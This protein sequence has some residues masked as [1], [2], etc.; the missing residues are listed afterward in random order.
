MA[1]AK[2]NQNAI[3]H[4]I[5]DLRQQI[6]PEVTRSFLDWQA[7]VAAIGKAQSVVDASQ[8][9]LHLAER[10]YE[11][12]LGNV[13]ELEDA[14]TRFTLDFSELRRCALRLRDCESRGRHATAQSLSAFADGGQG[15][16]GLAVGT[17]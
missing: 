12:G 16:S 6:V 8:E 5:E 17:R 11:L 7:A 3:N 9:E 2:Y 13:I 15:L 10:R 14:Q 1:Q 4:Q